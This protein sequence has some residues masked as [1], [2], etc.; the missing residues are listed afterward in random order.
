MIENDK[1]ADFINHAR[2]QSFTQPIF[3]EFTFQRMLTQEF[4]DVYTHEFHIHSPLDVFFEEEKLRS[5]KENDALNLLNHPTTST[6]IED[7]YLLMDSKNKAIA[8]IRGW[9]KSF[10]SYY[11]QFTAVHSDHRKKGIY[12]QIIDRVLSYTKMLGFSRVLSCHA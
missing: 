8:M 9:Q 11:M 7:N 4:W 10:D 3:E 12:S 6:F 1:R 2:E 5:N